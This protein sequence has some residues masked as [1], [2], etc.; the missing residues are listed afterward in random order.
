MK[1][2]ESYEAMSRKLDGILL[3]LEK[4]E[5]DLDK[6]L[7]LYEEG[8]RL[9]DACEAYLAQAKARIEILSPTPQGMMAEPFEGEEDEADRE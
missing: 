3:Q 8:M 1:K 5:G 7:K 2:S 9:A 6:A 4:G